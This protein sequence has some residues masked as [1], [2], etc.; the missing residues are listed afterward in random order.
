[1][2]HSEMWYFVLQ[3]I[4]SSSSPHFGT[5]FILSGIHTRLHHPAFPHILDSIYCRSMIIKLLQ[6]RRP[7]WVYRD[8]G[9]EDV[10]LPSFLGDEQHLVK[11]EQGALVLGAV[12]PEGSLE[13]ELSVCGQVRTLPVEQQR[14]DLLHG[15]T[16]QLHCITRRWN[17]MLRSALGEWSSTVYTIADLDF[18][19]AVSTF[20]L[21]EENYATD[22]PLA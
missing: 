2:G 13:N 21:I 18:N 14:L 15:D 10:V 17:G 5:H 7:V 9:F 4:S 8:E 1:M 12:E 19:R 11:E 6:S 22:V 3:S 20:A 16:E